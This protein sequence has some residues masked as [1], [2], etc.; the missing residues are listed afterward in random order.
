MHDTLR[1]SHGPGTVVSAGYHPPGTTVSDKGGDNERG[2]R[3]VLAA[4]MTRETRVRFD[5]LAHGE[6]SYWP[7]SMYS[8]APYFE[9]GERV[10]HARG[11][12]P[13]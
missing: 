12:H 5:D 6:W 8:L 4:G 3:S 7:A 11:F 10:I 2:S 1:P 9:P 13:M